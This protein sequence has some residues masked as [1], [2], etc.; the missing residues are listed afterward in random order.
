VPNIAILLTMIGLGAVLIWGDFRSGRSRP[1]QLRTRGVGPFAIWVSWAVRLAILPALLMVAWLATPLNL[2]LL[3]A[4]SIVDLLAGSTT[5]LLRLGGVTNQGKNAADPGARLREIWLELEALQPRSGGSIGEKKRRARFDALMDELGG[6]TQGEI[7][8]VAS[9][10][11]S[12]SRVWVFPPNDW[13]T[14][15]VRGEID[16]F[17]AARSLWMAEEPRPQSQA[18]RARDLWGLFVSWEALRE[19]MRATPEPN[20]MAERNALARVREFDRPEFG[21]FIAAVTDLV[22]ADLDPSRTG[23]DAPELLARV[24]SAH[25]QLWP[26][27]W[28]FRGADDGTNA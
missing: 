23:D 24:D 28:V 2:L 9:L 15:M 11:A 12:Q 17:A 14:E 7:G 18:S 6:M 10:L 22:N 16:L 4:L 21:A 19:V 8:R 25:H 13:S 26:G 1:H 20:V 27:V 5:V 3:A